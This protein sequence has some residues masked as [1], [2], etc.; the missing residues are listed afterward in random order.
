MANICSHNT[1]RPSG[2]VINSD[3]KN[4]IQMSTILGD[5]GSSESTLTLD[6]DYSALAKPEI[7][8]RGFVKTGQDVIEYQSFYVD[9]AT[10]LY[11]YKE[12]FYNTK[13]SDIVVESLEDEDIIPEPIKE[14]VKTVTPDV[15]FD[16]YF[17]D[18]FSGVEENP[19][20]EKPSLTSEYEDIFPLSDFD[21]DNSQ[22]TPP[23][24][25]VLN[26]LPIS[27]GRKIKLDVSE[28]FNNN[29]RT[30]KL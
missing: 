24:N 5:F 16:Q 4:N 15:D 6:D 29:K 27:S 14:E 10:L 23:L 22:Q 7:K 11:E 2:N 12:G 18:S 20:E 1:Q 26:E 8:G 25:S 17:Q 9:Q 21:K 3:L 13:S 30:I 19:K 28:Q